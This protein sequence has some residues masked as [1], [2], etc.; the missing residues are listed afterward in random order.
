M[1]SLSNLFIF[2]VFHTYQHLMLPKLGTVHV[3]VAGPDSK[4]MLLRLVPRCCVSCSSCQQA[5]VDAR[6]RSRAAQL[7]R[8]TLAT[9][10]PAPRSVFCS[11]SA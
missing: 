6:A 3:K 5:L 4:V 9:P 11:G 2:E 7:Y 10:P 8:A 1:D